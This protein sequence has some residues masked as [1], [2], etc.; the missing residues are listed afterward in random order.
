[1]PNAYRVAVATT[2]RDLCFYEIATGVLCNRIVG[3]TDIIT[4]IDYT[5][6]ASD[7][8]LLV[9]G[10]MAGG[11]AVLDL[12]Q[13]TTRL[14]N[15]AD[16]TWGDGITINVRTLKTSDRDAPA[17]LTNV[18]AHN[19]EMDEVDRSVKKVQYV[20]ALDAIVSCAAIAKTSLAIRDLKRPDIGGFSFHIA[21]G[22]NSFAHSPET[23]LIATAGCDSV[24]RLWNPYVPT[25]AVAELH[26]HSAPVQHIVFNSSYGQVI[27]ICANE[28]I[29]IWDVQDQVLQVFLGRRILNSLRENRTEYRKRCGSGREANRGWID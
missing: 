7:R 15:S 24:V 19:P 6:M 23:N 13:T 26:G 3:L 4:D 16:S 18:R 9:W 8:G 2:N 25:H 11:V 21:K 22:C 28:A 1:M 20:P 29:R 14:F 17:R 10:D 5:V 12:T 27:S